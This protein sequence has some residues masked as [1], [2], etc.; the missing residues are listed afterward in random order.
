MNH[1]DSTL[2]QVRVFDGDCATAESNGLHAAAADTAE[3][4]PAALD[5]FLADEVSD[6]SHDP[7]GDTAEQG[8]VSSAEALLAEDEHA[9][10]RHGRDSGHEG[11]PPMRAPERSGRRPAAGASA[12]AGPASTP[13][14]RDAPAGIVVRK[15][16]RPAL[17][18]LRW[19]GAGAVAGFVALASVGWVA[20]RTVTP[21]APGRW[22]RA[23]AAA[24]VP[25]VGQKEETGAGGRRGA[26][27]GDDAADEP[28]IAA[29][30]AL[31]PR[32][33]S[34]V[35][36]AADGQPV[37][38]SADP[39]AG[40]RDE[41]GAAAANPVGGPP[42]AGVAGGSTA[43][44]RADRVP[45]QA[46]ETAASRAEPVDVRPP[47]PRRAAG[48]RESPSGTSSR[49]PGQRTP[50]HG[51]D[52][53][54]GRSPQ[55]AAGATTDGARRGADEVLDLVRGAWDAGAYEDAAAI[56]GRAHDLEAR[57][58]GALARRFGR[59]LVRARE[60]RGVAA[61]P[62]LEEAL[63]VAEEI[64]RPAPPVDEVRRM[65]ASLHREAAATAE[66]AGN[67]ESALFHCEQAI[68][69]L[70]SDAASRGMRGRLGARARDVY[71]EGYSI[72]ELDPVGA[73][74]RFDLAVRLG[75]G[76]DPWAAK[77]AAR[78][79]QLRGGPPV[80]E[81]AGGAPRDGV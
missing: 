8:G 66:R 1:H 55:G 27:A 57:R 60:R 5:P 21:V 53:R 64:G 41:P 62:A 40:E 70:P 22:T 43:A 31:L 24:P 75:G 13:A 63:A 34:A 35:L 20:S 38:A 50:G 71:L 74:R 52:T 76:G 25:G 61:A 65:L 73:L 29:A 4:A 19:A 69:V 33:A 39:L 51:L 44:A 32:H 72:Q 48:E 45:A 37:L 7:G 26:I 6:L 9:H 3:L 2:P 58:L 56:G 77:A 54:R 11:A 46:A 16:P 78:A 17:V 68:A 18:L 10:G 79:A 23:A 59:A 30:G 47:R 67:L 42:Q 36:D 49:K 12:A 81:A 15:R 14:G 28:S 80:A